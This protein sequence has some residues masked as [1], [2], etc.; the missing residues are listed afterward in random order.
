MKDKQKKEE[1]EE[2]KE[3]EIKSKEATKVDSST[4]Y[5]A[6]IVGGGIV[7][8][9]LFRDLSLHGLKCLL[10]EKNDFSSQTSQSSSKMLH[11]GIRYLENFDFSLVR[12]ALH[13]RNL[14]MENAPHL[15]KPLPFHLLVYKDSKYPKFLYHIGLSLY[16]FLSGTKDLPHQML[17]KEELLKAIPDLKQDGLRGG[18]LYYDA[19]VDDHKLALECL[20]DALYDGQSHAL[21]Y[22]GVEKVVPHSVNSSLPTTAD[23]ALWRV[24]G[25]DS[26][27][28][29][30]QEFIGK[31]CVFALGPF[32]DR[33]LPQ[34]LGQKNWPEEKLLLSKGSHLWI[35]P[36]ALPITA[37][38]VLSTSD[39][40]IVFVIPS[41]KNRAILVGTT[42]VPISQ[43]DG[44]ADVLI[45]P[46]EIDYLLEQLNHFF[47]SCRVGKEHILSTF[48]GIRP[49]IKKAGKDAHKVSRTHHTYT[50]DK[51]LFAI[52]GGKYTTFRS[53][54]IPLCEQIVEHV[55][56]KK[57]AYNPKRSLHKLRRA[58]VVNNIYEDQV[59]VEK[60]LQIVQTEKVRT[61]HDLVKRRLG[62]PGQKHWTG[63]E[64]FQDFWVK[65]I[66][67]L[68]PFMEINEKIIANF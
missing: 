27:T 26:L 49:L 64:S 1:K 30:A 41:P 7:G 62:V 31:N 48:A 46:P 61:F 57:N 56:R 11:G 4:L 44:L 14:W 2:D 50:I 22:F 3:R 63:P 16:D 55:L 34:M 36:D 47:P 8:I 40:R 37:P 6:I 15:V 24:E 38:I 28:G 18:A 23:T 13:E 29:V 25:R 65:L 19:I 12:E 39:E 54:V 59:T 53:M 45:S 21:N 52:A 32:T 5:D 68:S 10:L 58:S 20:Y 60:I 9:S 51:N 35:K 33:G 67:T 66:P 17:D 42:E 43:N